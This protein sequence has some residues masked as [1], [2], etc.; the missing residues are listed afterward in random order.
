MA[1]MSQKTLIV[2]GSPT[3]R[4]VEIL[5]PEV[6]SPIPVERTSSV[7]DQTTNVFIRRGD[8]GYYDHDGRLFVCGRLKTLLECQ[9]RKFSPS[10]IEHCLMDHEAVEDVSVLAVPFEELDQ[11]PAAVV[12][13]KSGF[14]R[15]QQLAEDLK[16]YVA[17]KLASFKHLHGGIYF[18][19]ALPRNTRGKIRS[20]A[21][22]EMLQ[23]LRRMDSDEVSVEECKY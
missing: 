12:V 21:L 6:T 20:S 9:R 7:G 14:T 10:D 13:T 2:R 11:F 23:T 3:K 19:D 1:S 5:Q 18:A 15:D 8:I 4:L 16:R 17:G 22:R